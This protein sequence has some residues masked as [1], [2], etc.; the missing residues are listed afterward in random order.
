MDDI[1]VPVIAGLTIGIALI[2]LFAYAIPT[3]PSTVTK[4]LT[5]KIDCLP[6][7]ISAFGGTNTDY[8]N[9]GL[10]DHNGGIMES[11]QTKNQTSS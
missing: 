5:V 7:K 11:L 6:L 10:V 1:V 2:I 8:C 4:T 9:L 3:I